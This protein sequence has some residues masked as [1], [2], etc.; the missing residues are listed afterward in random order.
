LQF[1]D[2]NEILGRLV[3]DRNPKSERWRQALK[4]AGL[5]GLLGWLVLFSPTGERLADLSYDFS[6]VFRPS[7]V[8]TG[9]CVIY[10]DLRSH[11]EL[12]VD[13]TTR[14]PPGLHARLLDRLRECQ[15]RVVAFDIVFLE[16]TNDPS[17]D[18]R[19][20]QAVRDHG[21]VVVGAIIGEDRLEGILV[22]QRRIGPFPALNEVTGS[23][24]VEEGEGRLIRKH[25]FSE[26]FG[27]PGLAYRV[28][29]LALG[30]SPPGP[31]RPRWLNPEPPGSITS[32][33]Y[34]EVLSNA[35]PCSAFSNQVVFVGGGYYVGF[36]G[37][38]GT[39]YVSTPYTM[40]NKQMTPGVD[41]NASAYLNWVRDD[42]LERSS[43]WMEPLLLLLLGAL[44]GFAL[45]FFRP[46]P[47]VV[48]G[49]ISAAGL[50]LL[51]T[52][53][54]WQ[55]HH[56]F[57]WLIVAGL[58]IPCAMAWSVFVEVR[59]LRQE[60]GRLELEKKVLEQQMAMAALAVVG[61]GQ[62]TPLAI[63]PFS[64]TPSGR[65]PRLP[66]FPGSAGL[67]YIPDYE[68]LRRIGEGAYGEVW[69]AR[70]LVGS[71]RAI[72]IIFRRHFNS[73]E[74]FDREFKGIKAYAPVSLSH[75]ALLPILHVGRHEPSNSFYYIMELGD[76]ENT[77]D[78]INPQAY[79]PRN[80]AK[81]IKKMKLIP[82]RQCLDICLPLAEALEFLHQ[83]HLIHR[84]VKP[85]NVIFV[86]GVPKFADIGLVTE[87]VGPDG[88]VSYVGTKNYIAPEGPGTPA[89][90]VFSL[91]KVI[92][93]AAFGLDPDQF[94][95]LPTALIDETG[96]PASFRLNEIVLKACEP[97]VNERYQT[98]AELRADLLRLRQSL[99]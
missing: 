73:P 5:T 94:P 17:G 49:L 37:G 84:D 13:R 46:W 91:G 28:A 79:S 24:L 27:D 99:L 63:G 83:K 68:L 43:P 47:A 51:A 2:P 93:V 20:V 76:D 81:D 19:F 60:K 3:V 65:D 70:D 58:Q 15:A 40:L 53:L 87:F 90:D 16:S 10:M 86:K 89:A 35:I 32:Y 69:L 88:D 22:G 75:P 34:A 33:S 9:V 1:G 12:G 18:A 78:Q 67:P 66:A 95:N 92:Y 64:S 31:Y 44:F 72:K 29:E 59:R 62:T 30:T 71:Y 6:F 82:L 56:W 48:L 85:S 39:D 7:S 36:A 52:N 57:P 38:P 77:G 97:E 55:S 11:E 21:R 54:V 25:F 61:S 41:L 14:W 96:D 98:A 23:G 4:G 42:W 26:A 74:P 8:V 80:L 45:T 50:F